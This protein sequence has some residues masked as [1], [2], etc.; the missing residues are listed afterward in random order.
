MIDWYL[1]GVL[2]Y[3]FLT[4]ITPYYANTKDQLF[5]NI[6]SG[7]L[8]M[9]SKGISPQAKDLIVKL[10]NRNPKKRLGY[11][12]DAEEI[13]KHEFFNGIDW[14]KIY[15]KQYPL[16]KPLKRELPSKPIDI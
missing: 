6:I 2:L 3:E 15:N 7:P 1:L 14:E 13:K 5:N 11:E 8:R 12:T 10:L 16:E 4:G 9:P